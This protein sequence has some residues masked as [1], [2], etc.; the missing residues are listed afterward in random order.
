MNA[1]NFFLKKFLKMLERKK[2]A[3]VGKIFKNPGFSTIFHKEKN[4]PG[5]LRPKKKYSGKIPECYIFTTLTFALK[6][7]SLPV[8]GSHERL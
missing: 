2:P 1:R 7:V 8:T 4:R 3:V 6:P 5:H